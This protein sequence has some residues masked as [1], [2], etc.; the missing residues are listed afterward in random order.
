MSD[1]TRLPIGLVC[2]GS[3][4]LFSVFVTPAFAFG[5][6]AA[7]GPDFALVEG[8]HSCVRIGGHVRVQFGEPVADYHFSAN[9]FGAAATSAALRSDGGGYS[10]IVEPRHMRVDTTEES[11]R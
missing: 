6:C 4:L 1:H 9:H 3:S 5:P 11:Y 10:D 2:V 8:T 7:Y